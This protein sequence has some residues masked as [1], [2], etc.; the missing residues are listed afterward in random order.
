MLK[1]NLNPKRRSEWLSAGGKPDP[2]RP[3][4]HDLFFRNRNDGGTFLAAKPK[5]P[6]YRGSFCGGDIVARIA[7][8]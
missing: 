4:R 3:K 2:K 6:L 8:F 1:I 7:F 5:P